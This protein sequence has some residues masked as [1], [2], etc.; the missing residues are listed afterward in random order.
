MEEGEG[1]GE[2]M[3]RPIFLSCVCM[4]CGCVW[5]CVVNTMPCAL[6]RVPQSSS[7]PSPNGQVER[8][9]TRRKLRDV[10]QA[11]QRRVRDR[12]KRS[13]RGGAGYAP[14]LRAKRLTREA[15]TW[16]RDHQREGERVERAVRDDERALRVKQRAGHSRSNG[17]TRR[18]D[19]DTG[20]VTQAAI[21]ARA[22][23][24]RE[25]EGVRRQKREEAEQRRREAEEERIRRKKEAEFREAKRQERKLGYVDTLN[26]IDLI[27]ID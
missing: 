20:A 8:D 11:C 18:G 13:L 25:A 15:S 24:R 2:E 14:S 10:A 6:T 12:E 1:E 5:L 16:W 26:E 7:V 21:S 23:K 17:D 4:L 22:S 19:T 3:K 27:T 9:K